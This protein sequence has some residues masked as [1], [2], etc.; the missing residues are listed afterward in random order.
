MK[1]N[2]LIIERHAYAPELNAVYYAH[3]VAKLPGRWNKLSTAKNYAEAVRMVRAELR[4]GGR[5]RKNF[6]HY[7]RLTFADSGNV[8]AA[9][10]FNT[11]AELREVMHRTRRTL[12]VHFY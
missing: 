5:E 10:G 1:K 8:F 7:A 12:N 4:K 2:R 9:G 11:Y 3:N 6:P